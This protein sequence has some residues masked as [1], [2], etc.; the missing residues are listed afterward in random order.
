M[1]TMIHHFIKT[2]THSFESLL[3]HLMSLF[4]NIRMGLNIYILYIGIDTEASP[5]TNIMTPRSGGI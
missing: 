3:F 4:N 1:R 2:Q 5:Q